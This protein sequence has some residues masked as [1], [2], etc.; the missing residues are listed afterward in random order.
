M[1]TSTGYRMSSAEMAL[2]TDRSRVTAPEAV[3]GESPL[4]RIDAGNLELSRPSAD[5]PYDL[6]FNGGVKLIYQP[7]E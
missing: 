3:H 7:E 2:A 4:G 1:Q 6:V 5:A